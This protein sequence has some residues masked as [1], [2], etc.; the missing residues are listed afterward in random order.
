MGNNNLVLVDTEDL[1]EMIQ[2]AVKEAV[3]ECLPAAIPDEKM[4][5]TIKDVAQKWGVCEQTIW[6]YAKLGRI[7]ASKA[8]RLVRFEKEYIDNLKLLGEMRAVGRTYITKAEKNIKKK[9]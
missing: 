2:E 5:Y 9:K 6:R 3:N 1:R 7:K 8:G 4:F